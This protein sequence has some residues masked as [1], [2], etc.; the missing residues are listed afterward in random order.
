MI[1]LGLDGEIIWHKGC[2]CLLALR[3]RKDRLVEAS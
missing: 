2:E 1:L 3:R